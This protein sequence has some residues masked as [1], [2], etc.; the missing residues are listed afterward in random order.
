MADLVDNAD[1]HER[2]R[3]VNTTGSP[4]ILGHRDRVERIREAIVDLQVAIDGCVAQSP[5][6]LGDTVAS[7]ARHC[8][9]FL[10]KMVLGNERSPCLLDGDFC[11][12]AALGFNRISKVPT[13]RRTL[14]LVPIDIARGYLQAT[15]LDE[16]TREPEYTEVIPIG[17]Q[18]LTIDIEWPLPGMTHWLDQPAPEAPWDIRVEGLFESQP[19]QVL[20][21]EPWLGQQL[22]MFDNRGITL[23][24]VIR[25]TVNTEAAHSPPLDRLML[26]EGD[27]DK[28]RFRVVKDREIHILSHITI[29]GVRYSHAIVIQAALLLYWKLARNGSISLSEGEVGIPVFGFIPD[30]VFSP[31]QDWLRFDGG[32]VT[33]LGGR[34][35]TIAHRVRAPRG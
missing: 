29:C 30:D 26:P 21:C 35:Q 3:L 16:E 32:L 2:I 14:T 28:V 25:V 13:N 18:R 19:D 33:S 6:R 31:R 34:A 9:I 10:R 15:K 17:P 11:Q 22:V 1:S 7:L 12:M 27:E 5:D 23:R 20:D 8:S 4:V 24:D